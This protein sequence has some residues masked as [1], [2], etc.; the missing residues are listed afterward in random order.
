M[1]LTR[2]LGVAATLAGVMTLGCG[3]AMT[4]RAL[5]AQRGYEMSAKYKGFQYARYADSDHRVAR[6]HRGAWDHRGFGHGPDHRGF[7]RDR[8]FG[9][10]R[11]VRDHHRDR[12]GYF[13]HRDLH[14]YWR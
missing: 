11:Y 13:D 10:P 2:K 6:D 8:G 4:P 9:D 1:K 14:H 3:L 7:V 12:H 5:A